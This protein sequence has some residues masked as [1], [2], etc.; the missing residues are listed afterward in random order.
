MKNREQIILKILIVAVFVGSYIVPHIEIFNYSLPKIILIGT[1]LLSYILFYKRLTKK[2][3]LFLAIITVFVIVFKRFS[4]FVFLYLPIADKM[5]EYRNEVVDYIKKSKFIYLCLIAVAFYSIYYF[6]EDG[7]FAFSSMHEINQSGLAIFLLG[8]ILYNKNKKIGIGTLVFG[9]L[10]FSRSYY[11]GLALLIIGYKFKNKISGNIIK[12]ANYFIITVVTT[13]LLF[14]IG[15]FYIQQFKLGNISLSENNISRVFNLI[16][17][18]NFFRFSANVILFYVIKK[19]PSILIGGIDNQQYLLYAHSQAGSMGVSYVGNIPHNL[20]L[21]HL[22][23]YGII[24]ILETIYLSKILKKIVNK[25]NFFIYIS[26][27]FYSIFLGSG[28]FNYWLFLSIFV[29]LMYN[30]GAENEKN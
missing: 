24:S 10:T 14:V 1:S 18:S 27:I 6:G 17:Y 26:I 21:S 30:T 28:L 12:K 11:L 4:Y 9:L 23:M 15:I 3:F 7:R 20:F 5:F 25:E 2:D 29:M 13:I 16:D 19:H 22:K 8:I